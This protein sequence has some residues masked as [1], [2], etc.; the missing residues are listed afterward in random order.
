[1]SLDRGEGNEEKGYDEGD[2]CGGS[3]YVEKCRC[4][5]E[6]QMLAW[7]WSL[8]FLR[9]LKCTNLQGYHTRK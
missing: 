6:I 4:A 3:V 2:R 1:M 5:E 9:L 7:P 8:E